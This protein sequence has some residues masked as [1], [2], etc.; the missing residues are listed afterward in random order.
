MN[1]QSNSFSKQFREDQEEFLNIAIKKWKFHKNFK[2]NLILFTLIG[3]FFLVF[4]IVFLIYY[5]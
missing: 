1:D 4:A 5:L 2:R 3:I